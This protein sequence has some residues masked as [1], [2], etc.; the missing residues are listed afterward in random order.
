MFVL[1][2][3]LGVTVC[4]PSH[5]FPYVLYRWWPIGMVARHL[6]VLT[7]RCSTRLAWLWPCKRR[8]FLWCDCVIYKCAIYIYMF[9]SI[10]SPYLLVCGAN[11]IRGIHK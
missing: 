9:Y 7:K 10:S 2:T 11:R 3:P 4:D 1:V 8:E 5:G 6:K